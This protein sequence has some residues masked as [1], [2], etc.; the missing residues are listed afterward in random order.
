M[1][2]HVNI[3]SKQTA[4]FKQEVDRTKREIRNFMRGGFL[5]RERTLQKIEL[6][7]L[8]GVEKARIFYDEAASP[9]SGKQFT[10][11]ESVV[12]PTERLKTPLFNESVTIPLAAKITHEPAQGLTGLIGPLVI[13]HRKNRPGI[14]S[15][16]QKQCSAWTQSAV[17]VLKRVF[18]VLDVLQ[19]FGRKDKIESFVG[20]IDCVP[21]LKSLGI[22][23]PTHC[24][25]IFGHI[26]GFNGPKF[27]EC[28]R[29]GAGAGTEIKHVFKLCTV[30]RTR[31][32]RCDQRVRKFI[33]PVGQVGQVGGIV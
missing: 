28:A 18:K 1:R 2:D 11:S 15:C 32:Q 29:V 7:W 33:P 24:N 14:A 4:D 27:G 21:D 26:T 17:K 5:I 20:E 25:T 8:N 23:R 19:H 16:C 30:R 3:V 31:D 13:E 22:L 6:E 10:L 9:E 12:V